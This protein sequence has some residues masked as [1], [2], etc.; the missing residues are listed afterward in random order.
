MTA[1]TDKLIRLARKRSTGKNPFWMWHPRNQG[2]YFK[3]RI[4]YES[5]PG[6]QQEV[7]ALL[8]RAR[9]GDRVVYDPPQAEVY[10]QPRSERR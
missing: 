2:D 8:A 4:V 9:L 6:S 1:Q 10:G 5:Y 3:S 7:D